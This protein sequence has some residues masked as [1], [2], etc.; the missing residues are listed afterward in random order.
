MIVDHHHRT[1]DDDDDDDD[2]D[3][4]NNVVDHDCVSP[5]SPL[6]YPL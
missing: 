6:S 1:S 5:W 2:D 4:V 3:Q